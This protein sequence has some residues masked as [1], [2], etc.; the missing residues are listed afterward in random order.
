MNEDDR[1]EAFLLLVFPSIS[2]FVC[3]IASLIIMPENCYL[4]ETRQIGQLCHTFPQTSPCPLCKDLMTAALARILFASSFVFLLLPVAV[5]LIRERRRPAE[6]T[7]LF[8]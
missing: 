2:F 8:D 6:K 5:G 3:L 1:K 7:N 4:Y